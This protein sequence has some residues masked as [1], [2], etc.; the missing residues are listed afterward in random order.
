MYLNVWFIS[1][2]WQN[3]SC[4]NNRKNTLCESYSSMHL[5][6]IGFNLRTTRKLLISCQLLFSPDFISNF[7]RSSSINF[8]I[9]NPLNNNTWTK[10]VNPIQKGCVGTLN[11]RH[12]IFAAPPPLLSAP[13]N[14]PAP[15]ILSYQRTALTWT[16]A[17]N[18][19]VLQEHQ[20]P[21]ESWL[22]LWS[23][24]SEIDHAE[25]D[26]QVDPSKSLLY[27][28]RHFAVILITPTVL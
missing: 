11:L 9:H 15:A 19:E 7:L 4:Q 13:S 26:K 8:R 1:H 28:P 16:C 6:A 21:L 22:G 25:G 12:L 17:A 20:I 23:R 27:P 18:F 10:H 3:K 2:F 14:R 24:L 5:I